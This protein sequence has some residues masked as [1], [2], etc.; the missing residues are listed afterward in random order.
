MLKK[1]TL[2]QNINETVELLEEYTSIH[3]MYAED[4]N[5]REARC[6]KVLWRLMFKDIQADDLFAGRVQFPIFGFS[7]QPPEVIVGYFIRE[8]AL[9][10]AYN[11]VNLVDENRRKLKRMADYWRREST[12]TKAKAAFP[13]EMKKTVGSD[14]YIN[15]SGIA[16]SLWR[17][18]GTQLDY[19]KLLRLGIPGL[20]EEIVNH[21]SKVNK[22]DSSY[23]LYTAMEESLNTFCD[24]CNYFAESI[25]GLLESEKDF[26]RIKDLEEMRMIFRS[27]PDSKPD[28]FRAAAQIMYL[29]SA[30][31]GSLNYGRIDEYLG[32]FYIHDLETRKI[33]EDEALRLLSNLWKIMDERGH[34]Y[35]TRMT[36]GGKGRRN[37]N[38]ADKLALLIME[39]SRLVKRITPQLTLRFDKEQ[40]HELYQKGL[41][42]IADGTTYPLLYN[43][44]VNIPAVQKAF[45][46]SYD[47]AVQYI[48]F[49][50]GEYTL[51]H[52]SV[53]TPS[54]VINLLHA[55]SVTLHKGI[56]PVS[57]KPMGLPDEEFGDFNS[58]EELFNAYKKQVGYYLRNLAQHE[59]LEYKVCGEEAPYLF[60]SLLYDDCI[61]TGKGIFSGGVQHL[62]GTMEA[63]GNTN[64][65][66]SL[67]A[68]KKAV[69]DDKLFTLDELIKMLD[70]DFIGY[71]RE[72]KILLNLPK[73]GNDIYEVDEMMKEV[74][75]HVCN[76]TKDQKNHTCLDSYLVV[77]INNDTHVYMGENTAASADGRKA[78][79]YMA[80]GNSPMDSMDKNGVTAFLNSIVK[81]D[82]T[83]HAGAV[84]N[85]KF[86][87]EMFTKYRDK[88]EILLE[89]YFENG[90]AQAMITVVDKGE[91]EDAIKNPEKYPN[92]IVRVGGFSIKFV[93]L[94]P[95]T[96]R[97][98]L[99]RTLHG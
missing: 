55:L 93:D 35:D 99:E 28:S 92:L 27:I 86:S 16:F 87:K 56:D 38:N 22:S 19:D 29:Y 84:Q 3:K 70:A 62:G 44:D 48:P 2:P 94:P 63:Y 96:Q 6:F 50:C 61:K 58:F 31:S 91:L 98:I 78:G 79:E 14:N 25:S 90:G 66:D 8:N 65:A 76:Y 17:M 43:D 40:N 20:R 64:T 4:I 42:V 37:E 89:T 41:D 1:K 15:E 33:D 49:G 51:Y 69:Y 21:K 46:V 68:I 67:Y 57:G 7:P 97:E 88:L 32:D 9:L 30:I 73:Y 75:N 83:I 80:N 24:V 52:R 81:P 74:H 36:I 26:S 59:E 45:E 39:T 12:V 71:E 60:L 85:M 34:R 23:L 54:G 82:P 10:E 18:S 72:R 47:D 11:D 53:G 95:H 77:I 5:Q 13:E